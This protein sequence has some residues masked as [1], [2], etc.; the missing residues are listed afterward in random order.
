MSGF[1]ETE[2]QQML[3][4]AVRELA[5]RYGHSYYLEV[6]RSDRKATELW[7]ELGRYGYLGVNIP[8]AYGGAGAGITELAIVCEEL[9]AAGTPSFLLI[10]STAICGELLIQHGTPEQQQEWLP[11][12]VDRRREDGLRDHRARCRHEHA[13][14]RDQRDPRR[15]RLPA[16]RHE[17]LRVRGRRGRPRGRGRAHRRGPG[18]RPRRALAFPRRP[19]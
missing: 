17:V 3:R 13:Q 2:E 9:A 19:T 12:M 7:E 8:E 4:D 5:G 18:D 14:P 11:R 16:A 10:V 6:S 1:V 15:R